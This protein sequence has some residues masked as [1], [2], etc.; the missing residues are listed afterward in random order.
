LPSGIRELHKSSNK[1]SEG[2]G[3]PVLYLSMTAF[4]S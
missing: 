2:I 1:M 3:K 4:E